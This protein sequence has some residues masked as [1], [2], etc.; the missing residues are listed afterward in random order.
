MQGAQPGN[1]G[2]EEGIK[3][4]RLSGRGDTAE[5][6]LEENLPKYCLL[7]AV[8]LALHPMH[9]VYFSILLTFHR[10]FIFLSPFLGPNLLEKL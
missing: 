3:Q 10:I 5:L 7:G 2:L 8:S 9:S 1:G 6:S 4:G